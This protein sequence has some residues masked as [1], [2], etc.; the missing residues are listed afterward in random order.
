MKPPAANLISGFNQTAKEYEEA[1]KLLT[2]TFGR[3]QLLIQSRL[4]AFFDLKS[5]LPT[6]KSLCEFRSTF[7]GHLLALKSMD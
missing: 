5:P 2:S 7:E 3:P 6:A 1:V 4:W